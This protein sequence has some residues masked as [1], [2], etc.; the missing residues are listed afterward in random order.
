[1]IHAGPVRIGQ[2]VEFGGNLGG[3]GRPDPLKD[4]QRLPQ[5]AFSFVDGADGQ[6]TPAQAR[7]AHPV[8]RPDLVEDL[9]L[10]S[11]VIRLTRPSS[12][13]ALTWPGR[14]WVKPTHTASKRT[15][16]LRLQPVDSDAFSHHGAWSATTGCRQ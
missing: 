1:M 14:S 12:L 15:A 2:R 4:L 3:L 6:Q 7:T 8:Q 9:D 11:P 16:M 10:T 5:H 13:R